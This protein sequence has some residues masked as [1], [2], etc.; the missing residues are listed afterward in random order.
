MD[1]LHLEIPTP[2]LESAYRAYIQECRGTDPQGFQLP[3]DEAIAD[4][5]AWVKKLLDESQGVGLPEG[6]VPQTT[7]WLVSGERQATGEKE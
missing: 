6:W 1:D 4:F 5:P 3:S 2:E 7:Y